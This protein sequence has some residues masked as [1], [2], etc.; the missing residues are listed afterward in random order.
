MVNEQSLKGQ[1]T[2]RDES[3]MVAAQSTSIVTG[4]VGLGRSIRENTSER[5]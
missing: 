1:Q 2:D 3:L 5:G 4:G